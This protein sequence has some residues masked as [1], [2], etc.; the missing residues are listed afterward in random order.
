MKI[1]R[2]AN[3]SFSQKA[4]YSEVDKKV[5]LSGNPKLVLTPEGGMN[6]DSNI[7]GEAKK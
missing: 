1:V 7:F 2:G 4:T 6:F 3:T 5:T